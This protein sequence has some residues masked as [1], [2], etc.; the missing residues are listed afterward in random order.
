MERYSRQNLT[1]GEKAT[2]NLFSSSVLLIGLDGGLATE[3]LKNLLLSGVNSIYL[4]DSLSEL[5]EIKNPSGFYFNNDDVRGRASLILSERMKHLNPTCKI[6]VIES[7][8]VLLESS[9]VKP[10][11]IL[12]NEDKEKAI[13]L[14]DDCRL[15]NC[16]MI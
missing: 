16:K 5:K 15:N 13:K 7:Y 4:L 10:L 8:D 2:Q 12:C 1:L 9:E 6:S 3:I 14:N 11:V